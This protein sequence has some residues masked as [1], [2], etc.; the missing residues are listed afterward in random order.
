MRLEEKLIKKILN[1]DE[2][3][4]YGAGLMGSSLLKCLVEQP[5]NKSISAFIVKDKNINP[6]VIEGVPVIDISQAQKYRHKLILIALHEKNMKIAINDLQKEGFDNTIP[7]SFDGDL[8]TTLR[9]EW[10]D[11]NIVMPNNVVNLRNINKKTFK[12]YVVHS[13]VDKRLKEETID[14]EFEENIQ[15]GAVFSKEILYPTRDDMGDNISFKNKE[16]CELT[17]LYWIWKNSNSEFMGLSHYRRRFL[18]NERQIGMIV[19]GGVDIIVTVPVINI[20]TVREQYAADHNVDDWNIMIE[21]IKYLYPEYYKAADIVQNGYFYYAYNMFI[22][23]REIL[24]DYCRWLF[25]ILEY[26]E[27]RIK[28]RSDGYQNRYIGFLAERLLTI[29]II[30]NKQYKIGIAEKHFIES[31]C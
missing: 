25:N 22:T 18:L 13:E 1:E 4:I 17:A 2:I 19:S 27:K 8:W 30:H 20:R 21:A 10:I 11:R 5:Y 15:V 9:R 28:K 14:R 3:Y 6:K 26:C 12:I 16:Y 29:Y 7:I 23:S 31:E 24:D